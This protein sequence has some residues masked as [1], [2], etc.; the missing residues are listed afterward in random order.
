MLTRLISYGHLPFYAIQQLDK[1]V[2]WIWLEVDPCIYSTTMTI[3]DSYRY[4]YFISVF[5]ALDKAVRT[6]ML[7]KGYTRG[8]IKDKICFVTTGELTDWNDLLT[9]EMKFGISAM[10]LPMENVIY[11]NSDDDICLTFH[12][13]SQM[14]TV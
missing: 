7:A 8:S 3:V 9:V 6:T 5:H 10:V 12:Y 14:M 4:I 11:A 2:N 13:F 1:T